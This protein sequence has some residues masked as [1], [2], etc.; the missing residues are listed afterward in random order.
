MHAGRGQVR[1]SSSSTHLG[2]GHQDGPVVTR[3]ARR[4]ERARRALHATLSVHVRAALLRVRGGGE[5]EVRTRRALVAVVALVDDKGFLGDF[6]NHGLVSPEQEHERRILQRGG[7]RSRHEPNVERANGPARVLQH[8][9]AVPAVREAVGR[10]GHL[11]GEGRGRAVVSTCMRR[12]DASREA[13]GREGATWGARTS[14]AIRGHRGHQR[15]S[16]AIRG[17]SEAIKRGP[18]ATRARQPPR[19][20]PGRGRR[21]PQESR[22]SW[23]P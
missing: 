4:I 23:P 22:A 19:H 17:P 12:G 16:E 2:E 20:R 11:G 15:P 1:C 13:V 8:G 10:E 14:E 5:D 7:G 6:V 18:P 21:S 3:I 9:V